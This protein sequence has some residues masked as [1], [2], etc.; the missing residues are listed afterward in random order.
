MVI[1]YKLLIIPE[2]EYYQG[3]GIGIDCIFESKEYVEEMIDAWIK[4]KWTDYQRC[5]FELIEVNDV[6]GLG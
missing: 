1:G 6:R 3:W 2:G 4:C 5:E